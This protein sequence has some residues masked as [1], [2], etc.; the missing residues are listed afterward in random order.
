MAGCRQPFRRYFGPRG[1]SCRR[2][3]PNGTLTDR[4]AQGR[5][6]PAQSKAS[7]WFMCSCVS[8]E[9]VPVTIR[10]AMRPVPSSPVARFPTFEWQTG[11]RS[12]TAGFHGGGLLI[13]L[14]LGHPEDRRT[15]DSGT[16]YHEPRGC[17]AGKLDI[18]GS[19]IRPGDGWK[20]T[21]QFPLPPIPLLVGQGKGASEIVPP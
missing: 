16:T 13:R 2:A 6:S 10:P 8:P 5:Y 17:V 4:A 12:K 15:P 14:G 20:S 21:D 18:P 19:A 11:F 9:S 1:H 3:I 7:R